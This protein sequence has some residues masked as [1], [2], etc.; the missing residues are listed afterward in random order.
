MLAALF[1]ACDKDEN[2]SPSKGERN[3]LVVEDSDDPIDHLRYQ[4]F[5]E[6]GIPVYYNDTIGSEQRESV[7][8]PYTYYERLQIF[9]NPGGI[10]LKGRFWLTED[11]NKLQPVLQFLRE[12]MLPMIPETFYIPSLL[13]VDSVYAPENATAHKGFNTVV[14][15][16]ASDFPEMDAGEMKWWRGAVMCSVLSGGMLEQESEWL[17]KHFYAKS[18]AVDRRTTM[19]STAAKKC[20]VYQALAQLTV[21]KVITV[22]EQCLGLCGFLNYKLD[23]AKKERETYVPTREEDVQQFCETIF[24]MTPEEFEGRWGKFPVVMAKYEAMK[25]KLKEYGFTFE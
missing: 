25:G 16:G 14:C 17:K 6:F 11:K 23:P 8:G 15:G 18:I 21:D 3:W 24:A 4:I 22:E 20:Y 1:V 9:Y 10:S 12:E 19:Y 2:L 7:A 13:L 5:E